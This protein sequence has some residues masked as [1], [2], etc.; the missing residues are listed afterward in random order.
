MRLVRKLGLPTVDVY[1]EE[2]DS[3]WPSIRNDNLAIGRLAA[4]HLLERGLKN[5]AFCGLHGSHWSNRRLEGFRA[6]LAESGFAVRLFQSD[7]ALLMG[8]LAQ[9]VGE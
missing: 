3:G 6:G 5:F 7:K 2:R 4:Q 8:L 9:V 1:D